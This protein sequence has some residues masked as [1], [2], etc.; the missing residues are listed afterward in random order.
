MLPCFARLIFT[1]L[2]PA[3]KLFKKEPVSSFH[4]PKFHYMRKLFLAV[5]LVC[6]TLLFAQQK[7]NATPE[8]RA[9][10]ITGWMKTNLKLTDEQLAKVQDLNMEYAKKNEEVKNKTTNREDRHR[11]IKKNQDEKDA[12]LKTILTTEQFKTYEAKKDEM[13]EEMKQKKTEGGGGVKNG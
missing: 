13:K 3:I 11:E 6:S 1:F 12:K 7:K 8:Q 9:E 4:N 2:C 5:F 10:K